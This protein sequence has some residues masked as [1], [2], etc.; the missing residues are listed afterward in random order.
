MGDK[1]N[2]V[3][4]ELNARIVPMKESSQSY[5]LLNDTRYFNISSGF[6]GAE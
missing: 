4:Y 2:M 1:I 6:C 5:F 3:I